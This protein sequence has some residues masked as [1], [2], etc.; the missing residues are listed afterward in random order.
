[1]LLCEQEHRFKKEKE[2]KAKIK[3]KTMKRLTVCN[4]SWVGR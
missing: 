4:H 3:T 2:K 1:M